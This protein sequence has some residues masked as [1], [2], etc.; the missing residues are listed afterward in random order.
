MDLPLIT[1][2]LISYRQIQFIAE[3]AASVFAQTYPNLEIIL[4]D[5]CS[6]DD[7]FQRIEQ[8][9]Q[10]YNGPHKL[11]LNHNSENLGL[12]RHINR[13]C[14]LASGS[15]IVIGA[16]DDVFMPDRVQH[17]ANVFQRDSSVYSVY[18]DAFYIDEDGTQLPGSLG[19][20]RKILPGTPAN[21][22]KGR[23]HAYGC[24]HA[25]KKD[26]YTR[27]GPLHPNVVYEDQ[28][29]SMRS[30]LLGEI[31]YIDK[32]LVKYRMHSSNLA[33]GKNRRTRAQFDLVYQRKIFETE[34]FV[35]DLKCFI[36]FAKQP[37]FLTESIETSAELLRKAELRLWL[38]ES[39][40]KAK[41][42][43][44]VQG[45]FKLITFCGV[46]LIKDR[47]VFVLIVQ[48]S[49]PVLIGVKNRLQQ[50]LR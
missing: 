38:L 14:E 24:A 45:A 5:D 6:P 48:K 39:V 19:M 11:V 1:F 3:S 18:S 37:E 26:S 13:V 50:I 34:Q 28:A 12:A 41:Q 16:G 43:S 31:A 30:S 4:S 32:P 8:I 20:Y 2:A 42:V 44:L 46:S 35:R 10:Q 25:W 40:L 27:F 7:T 47:S 33:L 29:I 15:I 22:F 23:A 17:I 21:I 36:T 9:A 49:F